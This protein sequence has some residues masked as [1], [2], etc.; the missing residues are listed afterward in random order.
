MT[1][2]DNFRKLVSHLL[3]FIEKSPKEDPYDCEDPSELYCGNE[4]DAR[5]MG[6]EAAECRTARRMKVWLAEVGEPVE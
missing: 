4:D 6:E 3:D 5:R 2:P 1:A